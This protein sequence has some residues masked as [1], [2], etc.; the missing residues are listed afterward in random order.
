MFD[1]QKS[2]DR[3]S[4]NH[5]PGPVKSFQE[6]LKHSKIVFSIYFCSNHAFTISPR[7][8]FEPNRKPASQRIG[9]GSAWALGRSNA[10]LVFAKFGNFKSGKFSN[11]R[12]SQALWDLACRPRPRKDPWREAPLVRGEAFPVATLTTTG[13]EVRLGAMIR[14][15]REFPESARILPGP[16]RAAGP[17]PVE[18]SEGPGGLLALRTPWPLLAPAARTDSSCLS[19]TSQAF[20]RFGPYTG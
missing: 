11:R 3:G 12:L 10:D 18:G 5:S 9:P 2:P 6:P 1:D 19:S 15:D 16:G 7:L 13:G 8:V 17:G 20:P 14:Y 4:V